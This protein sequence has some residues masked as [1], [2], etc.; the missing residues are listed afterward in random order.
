MGNVPRGRRPE[1]PIG[2]HNSRCSPLTQELQTQLDALAAKSIPQDKIFAEKISTRV[3]VR[4]KFET[5]LAAARE[6]KARAPHCRVIV[7]VYEMKR[8]G[9]DA[10]EQIQPD[11]IIPTGRRKGQNP[12]LSSM[13]RALAEHEKRVAYPEAVTAAH[14]DFAA[15][16]GRSLCRPGESRNLS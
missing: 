9:R 14:T 5:A 13:Y 15:P 16:G 2:C 4:V 12:S 7:T 11:L 1:P 6:I 10:A 3:R 8:L